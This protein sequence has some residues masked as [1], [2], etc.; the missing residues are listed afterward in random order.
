MKRKTSILAVVFAAV[1]IGSSS[2]VLAAASYCLPGPNSDGLATSDVTFRT[3]S[4]DNCYGVVSGNDSLS[5]MNGLVAGGLFGGGW[6]DSVKDED[7]GGGSGTLINYLGLN[8]TFGASGSGGS[9]TWSLSIEDP[10]PTSL[11]VAVDIAAVVKASNLYAVYFFDDET[12]SVAGSSPGTW[13]I[14]F[15]GP[16]GQLAGWSHMTLYFRQGTLPPPPPP[17]P[18]GQLLPEPGTLALIGLGALGVGALRRRKRLFDPDL[19]DR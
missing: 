1:A 10:S 11:P 18:P 14:V 7:L 2:Q 4:S 19:G 9:G 13:Q 12:F 5:D 17:P 6:T 3:F 16:G 15:N 8:W